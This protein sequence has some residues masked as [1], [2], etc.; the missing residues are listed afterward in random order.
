MKYWSTHA[1]GRDIIALSNTPEMRRSVDGDEITVFFA[2]SPI[3]STYLVAFVVGPLE[4]VS[5]TTNDGLS[6]GCSLFLIVETVSVVTRI[7]DTKKALYSVKTAATIIEFYEK[8]FGVKFPIPKCDLVAVPD[9]A[10]G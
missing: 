4:K 6:N 7:G 10:M 1:N 9:F 5:Q 2:E 3:M 8:L